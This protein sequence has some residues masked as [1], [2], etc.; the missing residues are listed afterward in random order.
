MAF[1]AGAHAQ[2]LAPATLGGESHTEDSA[3]GLVQVI[4]AKT[5]PKIAKKTRHAVKESV[6][7]SPEKRDQVAAEKPAQTTSKAPSRAT[8]AME[9]VRPM[10]QPAVNQTA[11]HGNRFSF[12]TDE[13][14]RESVPVISQYYP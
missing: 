8:F 10:N 2:A 3:S 1:S 12:K 11:Q 6:R 4:T 5:G 13:G 7:T 9:P 14:K